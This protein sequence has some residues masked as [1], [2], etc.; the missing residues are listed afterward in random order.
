MNSILHWRNG[1]HRELMFCWSVKTK[2]S[3]VVL[4]GISQDVLSTWTQGSDFQPEMIFHLG[5][6]DNI[7]RDATNLL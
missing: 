3:D 6:F 2:L 4:F 1:I 5:I 7:W